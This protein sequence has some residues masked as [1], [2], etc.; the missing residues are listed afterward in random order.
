M[1]KKYGKTVDEVYRSGFDNIFC[2][3]NHDDYDSMENI[4]SKTIMGFSAYIKDIEPN[5]IIIH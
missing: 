4:L 1:N 3:Y 5:L 2:Y